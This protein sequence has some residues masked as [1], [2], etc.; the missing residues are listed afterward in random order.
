M[1]DEDGE[2]RLTVPSGLREKY[3]AERAKRLHADNA[4]VF[5]EIEGSLERYIADPYVEDPIVRDALDDEVNVVIIGGGFG[6][7]LAGAQLRMAGVENV[8]IIDKAA[9]FGGAWYWN[10]YP[11]LRCDTEALI[12]LP[13]LE[14]LGILPTEKY[15]TREEIYEH[16]HAIAR[17]YGLYDNAC[18]QTE[19]KEVRWDEGTNRWIISTD[20]GDRIKAR[21]VCVSPG[22][23]NR[24]RLP[25]IP[26]IE[27][28]KG[29]AFHTARWDYAYTGGNADGNLTGLAGKNIGIIGSGSTAIQ[30]VPEL[31]K[32]AEH[33]YVFQ[34]TPSSI[35]P[36]NNMPFTETMLGDRSPGWQTRRQDNFAQVLAGNFDEGDLVNDAWTEIF[37]EL[38]R[39]VG[40]SSDPAERRLLADDLKMEEVRTRIDAIVKDKETADALKPYYNLMCKRP[41]F[42][43]NYLP[44]F[45]RSNVTLVDTQGRGVEGVTEG[46]IVVKGREYK[47]DCLIYATGFEFLTEYA[48]RTGF[49]IIGQNGKSQAACWKEGVSTLYGIHSRGFPNCFFIA[50][51][52]QA[53]S[54]NFTHMLGQVAIHIAYLIKTCLDREIDQ[55]QPT[56]EAQDAWGEVIMQGSDARLA[57]DAQCSPGYYN[58]EGSP[59]LTLIRNNFYYGNP[60]DYSRNLAA[61]REEGTL[62]GL[63]TKSHVKT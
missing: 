54:P 34:R 58:N 39:G 56:Q 19:V 46:G 60:V 22:P 6:G 27:K 49:D 63:E 20:R 1:A 51:A 61:I 41:T 8:R 30:L 16:S 57:F 4:P 18:F 15:V 52:Q 50:N 35:F 38:G 9:D 24:P 26:G 23:L 42:H 3:K 5:V 12:Y 62:R 47:L 33:L 13:L 14:E 48:T 36:R 45:N 43:D 17:K 55:I 2:A 37:G 11:G 32:Y 28:F 25:N 44:T 40:D 21:F 10:R 29:H 53:N 31:A 7:L 59:S